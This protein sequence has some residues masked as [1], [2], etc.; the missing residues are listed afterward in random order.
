M[1]VKGAP[2]ALRPLLRELPAFYES[3]YKH[4]TLQG[5][6]V[7]AMAW[8]DLPESVSQHD[9]GTRGAREEQLKAMPRA[10]I[11]SGLAFCGFL[12]FNCP[13][14]STTRSTVQALLENR[15]RVKIITGDNPY[16]ACEIAKQ[17]GIVAPASEVL[18]L[19]SSPAKWD[20]RSPLISRLLY[21]ESLAT[22]TRF[23]SLS[24]D[25]SVLAALQKR[26]VLVLNG[27][28]WAFS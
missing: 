11:E 13:L 15:Y 26:F 27:A 2:E 6:R 28:F 17:C 21:W 14:K 22:Q 5:E 12:L 25:P 3:V 7:L 9:V 1:L 10:A 19:A 24:T 4:H 8:K 16:T 18:V 20:S 23:E